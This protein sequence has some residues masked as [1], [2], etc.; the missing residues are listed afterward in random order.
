[1]VPCPEAAPSAA[2]ARELGIQGIGAVRLHPFLGPMLH[3]INSMTQVPRRESPLTQPEYHR[4][5]VSEN[6]DGTFVSAP[7][8]RRLLTSLRRTHVA[9]ETLSR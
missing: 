1:M 3:P 7:Y 2:H 5:A 6:E 8:F 4:L 9:L